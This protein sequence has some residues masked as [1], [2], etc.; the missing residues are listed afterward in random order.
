MSL[1]DDSLHTHKSSHKVKA[2][3]EICIYC[4]QPFTT[5]T[6]E[7]TCNRCKHFEKFKD[8]FVSMVMVKFILFT[9]ITIV[10]SSIIGPSLYKY[11]QNSYHF[12]FILTI[13]NV[14]IGIS[15]WRAVKKIS[16]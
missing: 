3:W 13:L 16:K 10:A 14:I 12:A 11:T 9:T 6:F 4:Y 7:K 5:D 1:L 2:W 8:E 15:L